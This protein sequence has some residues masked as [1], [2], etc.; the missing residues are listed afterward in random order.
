M[1]R[2]PNTVQN[3]VR[4]KPRLQEETDIQVTRQAAAR[5]PFAIWNLNGQ[6]KKW[7]VKCGP[8]E[9]HP[10]LQL[11]TDNC[12]TV[13][14]HIRSDHKPGHQ[15]SFIRQKP[16]EVLNAPDRNQKAK[17]K[18]MGTAKYLPLGSLKV[19]YFIICQFHTCEFIYS[20]KLLRN[21]KINTRSPFRFTHR[22]AQ[23]RHSTSSFQ[24]PACKQ[25]SFSW[26]T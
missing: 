21:P 19:D 6:D 1:Q 20:L 5:G 26:S 15:F 8:Q 13:C 11:P 17:G 9:Q 10:G 22:H 7:G 23:G 18:E 14:E 4:G 24:C 3:K 16:W 2:R 25:V 12:G